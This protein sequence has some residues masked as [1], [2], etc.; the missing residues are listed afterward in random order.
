VEAIARTI[1]R[2]QRSL[3]TPP[4]DTV[5][6]LAPVDVARFCIE[7]LCDFNP[8]AS[9]LDSVVSQIE[10]ACPRVLEAGFPDTWVHTDLAPDNIFWDGTDGAFID[11]GRS[12]WGPAP[13]A[14][15]MLIDALARS[16]R[17]SVEAGF[18]IERL[19]RAYVDEWSRH[20]RADR[21][22]W[23]AVAVL[24][25]LTRTWLLVDAL[26]AASARDEIVDF[27]ATGQ[28]RAARQL[29]SWLRGRHRAAS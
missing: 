15:E 22:D 8:D 21:I 19:R 18:S 4:H 5:V 28:A 11:L 14:L 6:R 3:E 23:D 10:L 2:V 9:G 24:T 17:P 7:L 25:Q 13:I 29:Y 1:A 26:K 16:S 27:L 20:Q 12:C